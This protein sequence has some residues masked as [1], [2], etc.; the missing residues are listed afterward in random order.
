MKNGHAP[1]LCLHPNEATAG[2]GIMLSLLS[3]GL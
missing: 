1:S 3:G 2:C